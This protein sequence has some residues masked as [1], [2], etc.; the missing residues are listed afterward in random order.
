MPMRSSLSCL[1]FSDEPSLP[2]TSSLTPGASCVPHDLDARL[3][4]GRARHRNVR[5]DLFFRRYPSQFE[6]T[7]LGMEMMRPQAFDEALLAELGPQLRG[8]LF[9]DPVVE[10]F[11]ID[12]VDG[13]AVVFAR[14]FR[15]QPFVHHILEHQPG[16]A[17]ERI[18]E[19]AA[20]GRGVKDLVALLE[21]HT[22]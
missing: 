21:L 6:V 16:I 20:A 13:D 5:L 12:N 11:R 14:G 9:I 10:R 2:G 18:A 4:T 7:G 3:P 1:P 15:R 8:R 19:A 22:G 17:I